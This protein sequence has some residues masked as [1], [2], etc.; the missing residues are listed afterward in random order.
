M[1]WSTTGKVKKIKQIRQKLIPFIDSKK[2][3]KQVVKQKQKLEPERLLPT[4][5]RKIQEKNQPNNQR[6]RDLL[7]KAE[8]KQTRSSLKKKQQWPWWECWSGA[9]PQQQ[10]TT[11]TSITKY[12][13]DLVSH[14]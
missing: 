2:K 3:R 13:A 11:S 14:E 9:P 1:C 4:E 6:G 12:L 7:P 5:H 10:R 8:K